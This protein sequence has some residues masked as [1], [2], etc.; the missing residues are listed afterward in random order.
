MQYLRH[1]ITLVRVGY[2]EWC[3]IAEKDHKFWQRRRPAIYAAAFEPYGALEGCMERIRLRRADEL[4][5]RANRGFYG[6]V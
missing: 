2:G 1:R 3:A 4:K 6:R 5:E